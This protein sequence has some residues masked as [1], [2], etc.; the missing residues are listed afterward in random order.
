MKKNLTGM[1]L[2]TMLAMCIALPTSLASEKD[3]YKFLWLDPDKSVYVLQNKLYK[4][5]KSI[6]ADFGYLKGLS[7]NFQDT[8]GFSFST[9]YY[10]TE[11]WAAELMYNSYSNS[12]DENYENLEAINGSVPF[13]RRMKSNMAVLAIWSPFYGKINTFNKIYYFDWSFGAGIGKLE[14]ESNALT[15][16]DPNLAS[17]FTTESYTS[18]VGKTKLKFHVN[19]NIHVGLEYINTMYKAPGPVINGQATTDKYR[20][21]SDLVISIGFS[22]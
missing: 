6:Y 15:A 12:N 21:N 22:F 8:K 17:N 20:S 7:T 13:V 11:E 2:I 19:K 5:K 16:S 10:F 1:I 9:G 4:K 14:T 18:F 3:L